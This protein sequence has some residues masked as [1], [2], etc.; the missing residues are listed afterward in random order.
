MKNYYA[1]K[2]LETIVNSKNT[3]YKLS[4]DGGDLYFIV[5]RVVDEENFAGLSFIVHGIVENGVS[6]KVE[7]LAD[8]KCMKL[9]YRDVKNLKE[10]KLGDFVIEAVKIAVDQWQ[11]LLNGNENEAVFQIPQREQ[12]S[13]YA[14]RYAFNAENDHNF[15]LNFVRTKKS[16]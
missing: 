16:A 11:D 4:E 6:R 13:R 2:Q 5:D 10:I 3:Y 1:D 9:G 14:L 8:I 15:M 12:M 7:R